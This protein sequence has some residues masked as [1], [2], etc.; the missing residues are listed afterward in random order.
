MEGI[1]FSR[2]EDPE[3]K[4]DKKGEEEGHD[5]LSDSRKAR[6]IGLARVI[7]PFG[8]LISLILNV[9]Q[10]DLLCTNTAQLSS[11]KLG[12]CADSS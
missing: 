10:S 2:E 3:D 4:H 11:L 8:F 12:C 7:S 9:Q 1:K 5:T 6:G